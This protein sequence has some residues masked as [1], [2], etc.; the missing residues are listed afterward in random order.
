MA[1]IRYIVFLVLLLFFPFKHAEA[2]NHFL[3]IAGLAGKTDGVPMIIGPKIFYYTN[4]I[5]FG[6]YAGKQ[7]TVDNDMGFP[8]TESE[9]LSTDKFESRWNSEVITVGVT[10]TLGIGE[11]GGVGAFAGIGY[12][13]ATGYDV[14]ERQKEFPGMPAGYP[15]QTEIYNIERP[16]RTKSGINL[17]AGLQF[18][19]ELGT[20]SVEVNT[21]TKSVAFGIGIGAPWSD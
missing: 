7:Y 20:L 10:K 21:F 9:L 17:N 1:G 13:N 5:P 18:W 12:G 11:A 6:F 19:I 16:S 14:F 15:A 2:G 3:G 4:A 8:K